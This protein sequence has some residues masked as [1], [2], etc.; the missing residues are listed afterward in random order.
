M[1]D[2]AGIFDALRATGTTLL[3]DWKTRGP[4]AKHGREKE[5]AQLGLG[6]LC[7]T[8]FD[9]DRDGNPVRTAMLSFDELLVVSIR[10]DSY[11]VPDRPCARC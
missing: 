1:G 5:V 6:T 2:Y 9:V 8:T 4:D 11:E 10:P 7:S 3:L